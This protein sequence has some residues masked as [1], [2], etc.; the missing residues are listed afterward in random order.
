M[1][2]FGEGCI[3]ADPLFVGVDDLRL[4]PDSPCIDAGDN[5]AL[6]SDITTALDGNPRFINGKVDMGAFEA[7]GSM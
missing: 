7:D 6:P 5:T 4:S 1:P 2:W 3:D